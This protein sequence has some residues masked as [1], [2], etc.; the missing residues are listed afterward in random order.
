MVR[1]FSSD[2]PLKPFSFKVE[3]EINVRQKDG[4]VPSAGWRKREKVDV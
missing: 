2:Y 1:A 4:S 3:L